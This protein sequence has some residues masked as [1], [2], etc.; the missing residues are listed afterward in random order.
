MHTLRPC[1]SSL[2]SYTSHSLPSTYFL[3]ATITGYLT[4]CSH[5]LL[6]NAGCVLI[7][8]PID[9]KKPNVAALPTIDLPNDLRN[10]L[11]PGPLVRRF[12]PPVNER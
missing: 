5:S 6:V 2:S 4:A 9:M 12:Q 11:G 7:T 3:S 8:D 10:P 1:K